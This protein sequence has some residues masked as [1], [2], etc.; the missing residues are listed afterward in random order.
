MHRSRTQIATSYAPGALFTYEGGLGCCVSVSLSAPAQALPAVQKQLFEHLKEFVESWSERAMRARPA[1]TILPQQ[2]LDGVFLNHKSEPVAD[3]GQFVLCQPSRIGFVPDPLV[4]VCSSCGLLCEFDKP[5]DLQRNWKRQEARQDC[6]HSES[7]AHNW[8]QVDVVF[9]HW[10]GNYSGLSPFRNVIGPNGRVD[11]IRKCQN[12]NHD[13]YRLVTKGS[14]F[15]SDWRFQCVKCLTAKEV[16]QADRESLELLKPLMDG[17]QGNLPKEWNMLPVSYRASSVFYAQKD[18]F[19]VFR[20]IEVTALLATARRDDL[21]ARLMKLYNFPGTPLD[22][23]EV[24]RQLRE[25]GLVAE[26]NEYE[27]LVKI[28]D[29]IPEPLKAAQ[30][31]QLSEKRSRYEE[32]G[33]IAK[34]HQ[35]SP[36]LRVQV[37][38]S[39]NWARRY[40]PIR[41]GLE[42]SSLRAEVIERQGSDPTLP[43][44]SVTNPDVCDIDKNDA[45]ARSAYTEKVGQQ[46]RR[47]GLDEMVLLRGL[48]ICEFSFGYTRVSST[49]VVEVKDRQMPVRLRAFAHAERNKRP[50]YLLEQKNEGF[51]VRL[52]E[53]RVVAW[54]QAN[55][56]GQNMPP[57]D[58]MRLGGLLI[59]DYADFGRF[60]ESYRERTAD[61]R[62]QRSVP[63]Y[64]YLLLH[65]MAHHFAHAVIE[66]SGLDHG[67]IGEYVFP[68]DL[69]FLVYRKGMTPDLGNLSAMWRNHGLTVL[70]RLLWDR[71]LKCDGGSLCDQRGGACPA[72]IMAPDVACIGGNNLLS[73]AALN[74]GV[75]PSWDIDRTALTGYLRLP[76]L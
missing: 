70:D 74:G 62:T 30:L 37:E 35:E 6:A 16:V 11:K 23:K 7:K 65:T 29:L 66:F 41:L 10:A 59:E 63:S 50:I 68:A 56:I 12:C 21:I 40:N 4:F 3:S 47:T 73:R 60:L 32:K 72:C 42:H 76:A 54:L 24:I 39:Q 67:S 55:G 33:L 71:A 5:E 14:P 46:L 15:F 51:Y 18:S 19:I 9:A 28:L 38:D 45:G 36:R 64:V 20:D 52:N 13:E 25:N 26:C 31:N 44:I 43:A 27:S 61:S 53:A 69:S 75:P 1:P 2:C 58:D 8:R 22:H 49:P 17:G 34:Q 57:R 48:D